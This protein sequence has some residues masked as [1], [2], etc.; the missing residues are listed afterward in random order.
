MPNLSKYLIYLICLTAIS[1]PIAANAGVLAEA[2]CRILEADITSEV[3]VDGKGSF[4]NEYFIAE[5]ANKSRKY[6]VTGLAIELAGWLNSNRFRKIY[7]E[8]VII[9]PEFIGTV[10]IKTGLP[11]SSSHWSNDQL[12]L[13]YWKIKKVLGCKWN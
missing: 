13:E 4:S 1:C 10:Y 3:K 7:E 8:D 9:D 12:E 2:K 6:R 5:V 11:Y